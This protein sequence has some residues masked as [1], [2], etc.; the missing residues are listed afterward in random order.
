MPEKMLTRKE[1][2]ALPMD[3]RRKLLEG[4]A[5]SPEAIA[6]Y[7]SLAE[8]SEPAPGCRHCHK[9]TALL[10]RHPSTGQLSCLPCIREKEPKLYRE[11]YLY[12]TIH[13]PK[14]ERCES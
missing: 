9:T 2:L 1:I 12:A 13:P 5:N 11:V 14:G 3:E 6:Y 10:V 4:Q 7:Q 8:P